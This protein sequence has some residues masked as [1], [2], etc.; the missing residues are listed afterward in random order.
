MRKGAEALDTAQR[1]EKEGIAEQLRLAKPKLSILEQARRDLVGDK[2]KGF[3]PE[4]MGVLKYLLLHVQTDQ[5]ALSDQFDAS[6]LILNGALAKAVL[7]G[8]VQVWG[9][10]D[11]A[12]TP[13]LFE[14]LSFHLLVR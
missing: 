13:D 1:N 4:E 3:T 14:A 11:L 5:L 12:I 2:L 7:G 9:S 10:N 8:L 6:G